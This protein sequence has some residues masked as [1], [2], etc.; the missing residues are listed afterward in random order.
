[1]STEDTAWHSHSGADTARILDADSTRG[2]AEAQV[3]ERLARHGENRLAE[4]PPGPSGCCS[5]TSSR[6][7]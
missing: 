5:R 1:M 2:L 6:A 3:G 7:C 4:K